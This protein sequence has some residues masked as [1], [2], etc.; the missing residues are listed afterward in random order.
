MRVRVCCCRLTKVTR[1][2]TLMSEMATD[3][4]GDVVSNYRLL[5]LLGEGAAG[6]VYMATPERMLPIGQPG[7]T[8]ALKLYKPEIL[9]NPTEL[10]RIK[11]EFETGKALTHPN[12]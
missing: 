4:S 10:A 1:C 3:Q 5:R 2:D 7:D 12:L 9:E 8:L 11:R 6:Q